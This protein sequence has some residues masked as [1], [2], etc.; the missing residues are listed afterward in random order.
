MGTT[1]KS[2]ENNVFL[3][4]FSLRIGIGVMALAFPFV[5]LLGGLIVGVP[6]QNSMSAYYHAASGTGSMRDWFVGILFGVAVFLILYRGYRPLENWLLNVGGAFAIGV[7]IFPMPWDCTVSCK[8]TPHGFCAVAFFL[9]LAGVCLFCSRDTLGL[10]RDPTRRKR[11]QALYTSLGLMMLVLPLTAWLATTLFEP[12]KV[13]FCIEVAGIAAF[14]AYWLTKSKE[15]KE[16]QL[17]E[18]VMKGMIRHIPHAPLNPLAHISEMAESA[19]SQVS[20]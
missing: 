16:S 10:I 18:K 17:D 3:T 19:P 8:W 12:S 5:L 2:L 6:W 4:Y 20:N 9:C 7:A 15:L 11:Y 1:P 14:S 13:I